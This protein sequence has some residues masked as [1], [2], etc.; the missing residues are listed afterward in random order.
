MGC[1]LKQG[2]GL[3]TRVRVGAVLLAAGQG[4]RM[5]NIPKSLIELGGV[6]LINRQLIAL[7][8][9]GVDEVVVV[10]GFYHE[11]I[12][13]LV[14]QFPVRVVR[15]P[16]PEEGQASSVRLGIEAL[17]EAFDAVIMAL[18]D[19][20]LINAEDVA[21]LIAAFK[22]RP[23]GEI[24]MPVVA[25]QRGNPIILSGKAL[26]DILESGKN[27]VCRKFMDQNPSL[28]HHFETP[29]QH[30]VLDLD[31]PKDIEQFEANTGWKLVLPK[32]KTTTEES[33]NHPVPAYLALQKL[34]HT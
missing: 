8:G 1:I 15:N 9:G 20:P 10:T 6:P 25:G 11:Q 19:Q 14:E 16:H 26:K 22:K 24:L 32:V 28:V 2:G 13:P 12:E 18:A 17:G 31:E 21:Q 29:N 7:S 34:L 4:Q 5:G 30:F 23:S 3:Y 27:M 33:S